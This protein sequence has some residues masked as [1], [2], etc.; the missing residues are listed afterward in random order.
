MILKSLVND[1]FY[2]EIQFG[3]VIQTLL[4]KT[5]FTELSDYNSVECDAFGLSQKLF[6]RLLYVP[7]IMNLISAHKNTGEPM[8]TDM[9]NRLKHGKL[10]YE[11]NHF[12]FI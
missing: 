3:K 10:K 7:E 6:D 8:P 12:L 2:G 1:Q 5:P 9:L 11:N 4:T